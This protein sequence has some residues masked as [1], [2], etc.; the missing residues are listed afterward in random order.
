MS[1]NST[2][3]SIIFVAKDAKNNNIPNGQLVGGEKIDLTI[4]VC[5]TSSSDIHYYWYVKKKDETNFS[6]AVDL[7]NTDTYSIGSI[8]SSYDG[9]KF[10]C[11]IEDA[12]KRCYV[13]N[14]DLTISFW[15][16]F[17]IT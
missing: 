16:E 2:L 6:L 9:A 14:N 12:W 8:D 3:P 11:V 17:Q 10:Y 1:L 13:V 7:I 5:P 4:S 15:P